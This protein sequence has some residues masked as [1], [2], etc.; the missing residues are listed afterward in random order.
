MVLA[1]VHAAVGSGATADAA[2]ESTVRTVTYLALF[3]G[4]VLGAIVPII[5]TGALVSTAAVTSLHSA[6]PWTAALVIVIGALA[7][8][9]GDMVLFWLCSL[10]VGDRLL[11]WLR[12]RTSPALLERYHR[13]LDE[14]GIGVLI[15]SRLIPGG[16]VPIMVA[17]LVLGV[18]WRWYLAGDAVAAVAWALTYAAIGVLSGSLFDEQWK[19][20]ALAIGLV[21]LVSVGPALFRALRRRHPAG[22]PPSP[23]SS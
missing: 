6:H 2:M 4:V 22:S 3:G 17:T 7:A 20:I 15:L 9:I 5:P 14:H 21:V 1:A 8:L 16:R 13:Q 12:G 19:G 18:T 10:P 11:A 23:T